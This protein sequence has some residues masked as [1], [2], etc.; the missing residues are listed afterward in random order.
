MVE[1]RP[2]LT[3][4]SLLHRSG[5]SHSSTPPRRAALQI[6]AGQLPSPAV[7]ASL[8]ARRLLLS[9]LRRGQRGRPLPCSSRRVA[10]SS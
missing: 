9:P 4:P 8:S 5:H 1:E 3:S 2:C 10:C 6:S 7:V